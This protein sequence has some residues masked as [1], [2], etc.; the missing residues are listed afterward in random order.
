VYSY[1]GNPTQQ[2]EMYIAYDDFYIIQSQKL[3]ITSDCNTIYPATE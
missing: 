2:F 1:D 3:N